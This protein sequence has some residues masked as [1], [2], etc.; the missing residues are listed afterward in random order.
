MPKISCG[1]CENI[2]DSHYFRVASILD[3]EVKDL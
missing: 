1:E 3:G 2:F